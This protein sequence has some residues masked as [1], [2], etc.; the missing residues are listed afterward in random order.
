MNEIP[1]AAAVCSSPAK[2][3][4]NLRIRGRRADGYH[5][6][7]SDMVAIGV[8]DSIRAAIYPGPP[9]VELS[10]TGD[11]APAGPD[12]LV[13][14]AAQLIVARCS[15]AVCLRLW[16]G[17]YIPSRAGL[18]G[19]SSDAAT[20]LR[21]V[22]YLARAG[23]S[24]ADLEEMALQLGADVP[25]FV[26]C[27]PSRVCGIG[28]EMIPLESWP[29]EHLVVAFQGR[30][31]TTADVY[32]R[33]DASL[34]SPEAVSSIRVFPHLPGTRHRNDLEPAASRMDPGVNELKQRLHAGGASGVGMSG[35][36]SAV[37][38]FF[39]DE[40]VARACAADL[41]KDGVWAKATKAIVGPCPV[42][43]IE[44]EVN[45]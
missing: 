20:T 7:E 4:L 13:Y 24:D 36:G 15:L 22:N 41:S 25:F 26:S 32:A 35:S 40:A 27:R 30:G 23:L 19:G 28:E 31:L 3:N 21:L 2:I 42:E 18:G 9:M 29:E 45:W 39:P 10:V 38:G 34:T 37:F 16:L 33:F 11:G 43:R 5:L 14:R 17:K 8:F 44:S 12:N 6:I 1:I